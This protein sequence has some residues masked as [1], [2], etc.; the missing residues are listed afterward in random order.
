MFLPTGPNG[1]VRRAK[2][3]D[4][5]TAVSRLLPVLFQ[6]HARFGLEE[7]GLKVSYVDIVYCPFRVHFSLLSM[8]VQ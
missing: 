1:N 6:K 8:L 5:H 4:Y 3:S 2:V 7:A